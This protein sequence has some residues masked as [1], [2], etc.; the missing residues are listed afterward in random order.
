MV[1]RWSAS[2][3]GLQSDGFLVAVFA[4]VGQTVETTDYE[5]GTAAG[6]LLHF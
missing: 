2:V 1:E 5:S 3:G 6:G 4:G